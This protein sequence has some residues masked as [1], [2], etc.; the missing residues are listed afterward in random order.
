MHTDLKDK[1]LYL[2]IIAQWNL[3]PA[4]SLWL[5]DM[6][7]FYSGF[8]ICILHN[9]MRWGREH[10]HFCTGKIGCC[11]NNVNDDSRCL[12]FYQNKEVNIDDSKE[13]VWIGDTHTQ[14]LSHLLCDQWK[15]SLSFMNMYLREDQATEICKCCW[16]YIA[17]IIIQFISACN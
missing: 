14:C 17:I 12:W 7:S 6:P 8:E 4:L 11:W 9:T 2:Q 1:C 3:D 13:T 5:T 16:L 10:R 15:V